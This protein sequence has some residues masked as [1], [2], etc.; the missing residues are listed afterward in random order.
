MAAG[1]DLQYCLPIEWDEKSLGERLEALTGRPLSISIT[2]NSVSVLSVTRDGERTRLRLH[3]IFLKSGPDVIREIA[4]FIKNRKKGE[5]FPILRRYIRANGRQIEKAELGRTTERAGRFLPKTEGKFH[6]LSCTY[7]SLNREYFSGRLI[8][9]IT[10]GR[11][12]REY[13]VKKRTLGSYS[14]SR[15]GGPGLIRINPILDRKS[16]PSYYIRFVVY[17]EMLHAD[18][19][20]IKKN[21]R[22]SIHSAEFKRRER[23]FQEYEKAIAWEAYER[24]GC[25]MR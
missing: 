11:S 1:E 22:R 4:R 21:G 5:R 25:K 2:S 9:G 19:G 8:C 6:D 24:R 16:V 20:T 15:N 23:L 13:A 14:P 7:G 17:H 10:W 12:P 3:R 18:I